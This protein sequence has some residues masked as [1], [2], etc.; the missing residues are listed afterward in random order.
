MRDHISLLHKVKTYL[1]ASTTHG[2][3]V[4]A[5]RDIEEGEVIWERWFGSFGFHGIADDEW[6]GLPQHVKDKLINYH[7]PMPDGSRFIHLQSGGDPFSKPIYVNYS[8]EPNI[9]IIDNRALRD[10]KQGEELFSVYN[11]NATL[12]E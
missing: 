4:F 1:G 5:L 12:K 6:K 10:I 8:N 7:Q 11:L 9:S 3:G 2:V